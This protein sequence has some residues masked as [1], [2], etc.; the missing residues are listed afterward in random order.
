MEQ[1]HREAVAADV[2]E[3]EVHLE[4]DL[5]DNVFVR[6]VGTRFLTQQVN[7]VTVSLVR[8]AELR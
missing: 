7:P 1:A 2:G 6:V 8:S 3:W 5:V 4:Q